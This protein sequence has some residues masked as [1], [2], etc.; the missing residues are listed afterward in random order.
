[1]DK[2]VCACVRGVFS[3]DV[4]LPVWSIEQPLNNY[5]CDGSDDEVMRIRITDAERM[6]VAGVLTEW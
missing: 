4:I 3:R 6:G 5:L 1:M 2:Y